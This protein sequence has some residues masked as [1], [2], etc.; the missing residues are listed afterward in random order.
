MAKITDEAGNPISDENGH[1]IYDLDGI[2]EEVAGTLT[3]DGDVDPK[4]SAR[5]EVG[6]NM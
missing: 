3:E 2:A 1:G 5:R 4:Y 6:G